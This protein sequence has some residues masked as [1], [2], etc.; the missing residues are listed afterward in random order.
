MRGEIE[1]EMLD[2]KYY[3]GSRTAL[4]SMRGLGEAVR[5]GERKGE[6]GERRAG[7]RRYYRGREHKCKERK[8]KRRK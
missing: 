3:R 1:R 4:S 5:R 7:K 2:S 6:R 8:G